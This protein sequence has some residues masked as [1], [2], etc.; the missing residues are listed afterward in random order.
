MGFLDPAVW[1][2]SVAA[3]VRPVPRVYAAGAANCAEIAALA[4][5]AA[6]RRSTAR[7]RRAPRKRR[8]RVLF[9][10]IRKD[11]PRSSRI[12]VRRSSARV[13]SSAGRREDRDARVWRFVEALAAGG[14]RTADGVRTPSWG[15]RRG[16]SERRRPT[17]AEIVAEVGEEATHMIS[18]ICIR[19]GMWYKLHLRVSDSKLASRSL[20]RSRG[21]KHSSSLVII[22]STTRSASTRRPLLA[23]ARLGRRDAVRP[24]DDATTDA[25]THGGGGVPLV[26]VEGKRHSADVLG[27]D[28]ASCSRRW[29]RRRRTRW[30]ARRRR[31][32]AP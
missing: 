4:R 10:R 26:R 2:A 19:C 13:G 6:R 30:R 1:K 27:R 24:S 23:R 9:E 18:Y 28:A 11:P 14:R 16:A 29:R 17:F 12:S 8:A 20:L 15:S 21:K 5:S 31:S 7:G 32:S 25:V 22:F 3:L